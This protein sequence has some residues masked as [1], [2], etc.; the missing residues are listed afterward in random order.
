MSKEYW[1]SSPQTSDLFQT[2]VIAV[3]GFLPT[4][5]GFTLSD[6][7]KDGF[8]CRVL[9]CNETTGLLLNYEPG[10][11]R[12]YVLL[13]RLMNGKV[14]AYQ[15][16]PVPGS[17]SDYFYLE[18]ILAAKNPNLLRQY[19]SAGQIEM[20][21]PI[22]EEYLER[23]LKNLADCVLAHCKELF[24]GDFSVFEK[25]QELLDER[26]RRASS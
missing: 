12:I 15:L 9:F 8:G 25:A 23:K 11:L 14:P 4:D 17:R 20:N 6:I 2:L 5:Y 21:A 19:A 16:T 3:F 13:Y 1:L 26:V 18:D 7:E 22:T 24:S 10:G